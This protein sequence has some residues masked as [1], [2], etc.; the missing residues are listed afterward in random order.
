MVDHSLSGV[1]REGET[2]RDLTAWVGWM[3]DEGIGKAREQTVGTLEV[4]FWGV[5]LVRRDG[6]LHHTHYQC[7]C[8]R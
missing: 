2:C 6:G 5:K 3:E 1:A 4:V 7:P 8:V